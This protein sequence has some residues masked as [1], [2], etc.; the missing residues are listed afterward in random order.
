MLD[1]AEGLT[2]VLLLKQPEGADSDELK[3]NYAPTIRHIYV[4]IPE[5]AQRVRYSQ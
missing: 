1:D 2:R 5:P 4:L 3:W